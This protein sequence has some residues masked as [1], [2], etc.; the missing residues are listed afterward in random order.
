MVGLY[1]RGGNCALSQAGKVVQAEGRLAS[2]HLVAREWVGFRHDT[3]ER[4]DHTGKVDRRL[5]SLHARQRGVD[6]VP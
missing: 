4:R 5:G 2:G 3:V 6:G 1:E